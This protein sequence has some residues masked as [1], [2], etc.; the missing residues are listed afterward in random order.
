MA[1]DAPRQCCVSSC[2]TVAL[3]LLLF[4]LVPSLRC[5][6]WKGLGHRPPRNLASEGVRKGKIFFNGKPTSEGLWDFMEPSLQCGLHQMRLT[7]LGRGAADWGLDLG[8]G[9]SQPLSKALESCGYLLHQNAF[10]FV[11]VIPYDGCNVI[12]EDGYYVLPMSYLRTSITLACPMTAALTTGDSIPPIAGN[13]YRSKR[14][15]APAFSSYDPYQQHY[16]SYLYYLYYMNMMANH[17]FGQPVYNPMYYPLR[18]SPPKTTTSPQVATHAPSDSNQKFAMPYSIYS[19]YIPP[20]YPNAPYCHMPGA[21]CP[22]AFPQY[23]PGPNQPIEPTPAPTVARPSTVAWPPTVTKAPTMPTTTSRCKHAGTPTTT[24]VSPRY[25]PTTTT[26]T[27]T[28]TTTATKSRCKLRTTTSTTKNRNF[29]PYAA[30][31]FAPEVSYNTRGETPSDPKS[32][33]QSSYKSGPLL[34]YQYWQQEPWVPQAVDEDP[35]YDWDDL[36]P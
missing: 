29:T 24:T 1:V 4:A 7:V 2:R 27:S 9:Q 13:T 30:A 12:Q 32:V 17:Q 3:V 18:Y 15:A 25:K 10:G 6:S 26:A 34:N 28:S 14:Y 31:P 19:H 33:P 23:Y 16:Y 8:S 11:L 21:L 35:D 5:F 22:I 36:D 20:P